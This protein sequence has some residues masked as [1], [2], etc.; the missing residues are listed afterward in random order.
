VLKQKK[1]FFC[2]WP[3]SDVQI[4]VTDK[5]F[6]SFS[7]FVNVDAKRFTKLDG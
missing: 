1:M 4:A 6:C 2:S 3:F 7:D 5:S